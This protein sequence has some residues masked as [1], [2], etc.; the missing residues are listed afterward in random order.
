M[1]WR[2]GDAAALKAARRLVEISETHGVDPKRNVAIFALDA[3]LAPLDRGARLWAQTERIKATTLAARLT[4]EERLWTAA[5][6]ACAGL[7]AFF[8]V[9]TRGLWR[10][11]MEADG[12]FVDEPA[13]ASSFYHIVCAIAELERLAGA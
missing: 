5:A 9:P 2:P 1:R 8:A 6:Q 12:G 7:E 13:P 10:D 3:G 11:W 4:G